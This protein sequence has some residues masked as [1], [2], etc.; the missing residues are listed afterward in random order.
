M[1]GQLNKP[2][3]DLDLGFCVRFSTPNAICKSISETREDSGQD[4]Y[5]SSMRMD[6][7][8]RKNT[9]K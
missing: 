2:Q 5:S 6:G 1:E 3:G 8:Q 4:I 7:S 9:V